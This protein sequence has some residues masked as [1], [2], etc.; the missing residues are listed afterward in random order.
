MVGPP[1]FE[2]RSLAP[3]ARRMGQA[4]LRSLIEL[5]FNFVFIKL[6]IHHLFNV[7]RVFTYYSSYS[8]ITENNI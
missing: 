5:K 6:S 1:R 3:K 2:R 4:T 7:I 8:L